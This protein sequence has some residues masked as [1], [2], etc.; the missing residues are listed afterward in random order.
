MRA[1]TLGSLRLLHLTRS[2]IRSSSIVPSDQRPR[3]L[4][5][6]FRRY[7]DVLIRRRCTRR[8]NAG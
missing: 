6:E 1:V 7:E 8:Q 4:A 2:V 5:L 3:R